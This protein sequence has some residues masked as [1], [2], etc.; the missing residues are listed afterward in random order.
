[1]QQRRLAETGEAAG[2]DNCVPMVLAKDVG[3]LE[4]AK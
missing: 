1:M 2:S 4:K 3:A